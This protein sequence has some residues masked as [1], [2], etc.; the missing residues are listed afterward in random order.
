VLDVAKYLNSAKKNPEAVHY[1]YVM[2][3]N[4]DKIVEVHRKRSVTGRNRLAVAHPVDIQHDVLTVET[5][6]PELIHNNT[7]FMVILL[8]GLINPVAVRESIISRLLTR[9]STCYIC[10]RLRTQRSLLTAVAY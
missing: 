6:L 5:T 1:M 3:S 8:L 2:F 9:L 7:D 10:V 4:T